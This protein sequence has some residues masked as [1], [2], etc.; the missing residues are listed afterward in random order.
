MDSQVNPILL[1]L[2]KELPK[3]AQ[4]LIFISE[5]KSYDEIAAQAKNEMNRFKE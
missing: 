4:S 3:P 5:S 1:D 2:S